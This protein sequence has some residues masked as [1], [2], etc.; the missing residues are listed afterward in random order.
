MIKKPRCEECT[1]V[2]ETW[3][4]LETKLTN[5]IPKF[6]MLQVDC[7]QRRLLCSREN[8]LDFPTVKFYITL[9]Q[10]SYMEKLFEEDSYDAKSLE[11][12]IMDKI[13]EYENK[14]RNDDIG[15]NIVDLKAKNGL[16]ELTDDDSS[17]FLSQ[18]LYY[19]S[20]FSYFNLI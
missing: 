12:F 20:C 15:F 17:L 19:Y 4:K 7:E 16:Y 3:K 14:Q 8:I 2:L 1:E 9:N 13:I 10:L 18:G 5:I 6:A 11:L